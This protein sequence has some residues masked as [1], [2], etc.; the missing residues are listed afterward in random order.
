MNER[1]G[2]AGAVAVAV[3]INF[4]GLLVLQ[5]LNE[6]LRNL[7]QHSANNCNFTRGLTDL[8]TFTSLFLASN[9][10]AVVVVAVVVVL[11][12]LPYT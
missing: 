4:G 5:Q 11:L 3:A 9:R 2:H 7:L 8:A 12:L 6:D 1:G 10:L